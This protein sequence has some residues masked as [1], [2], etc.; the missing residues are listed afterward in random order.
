MRFCCTYRFSYSKL[1]N[2][3]AYLSVAL[4][5]DKHIP[6]SARLIEANYNCSL[7]AKISR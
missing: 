5:L 7:G 2:L 3:K 1:I 6:V 4:W